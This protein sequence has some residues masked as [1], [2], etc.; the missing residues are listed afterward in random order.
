MRLMRGAGKQLY[1]SLGMLRLPPPAGGANDTRS[2]AFQ[3]KGAQ[4]C[5]NSSA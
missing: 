4:L 5:S 2:G 3:V 1:S